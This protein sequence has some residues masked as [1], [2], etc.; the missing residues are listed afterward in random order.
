MAKSVR[1]QKW[2][3]PGYNSSNKNLYIHPAASGGLEHPDA[4]CFYQQQE[5]TG[6]RVLGETKHL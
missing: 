4:L 1:T 2:L 3:T 5:K 6:R